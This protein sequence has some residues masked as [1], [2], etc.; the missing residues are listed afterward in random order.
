MNPLHQLEL[1]VEH[2]IKTLHPCAE[3][4]GMTVLVCQLEVYEGRV[5]HGSNVLAATTRGSR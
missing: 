2:P 1:W 5:R 4:E 3:C